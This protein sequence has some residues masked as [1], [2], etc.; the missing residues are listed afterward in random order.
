MKYII[1]FLFAL[2]N[3][4]QRFLTIIITITTKAEQCK[5]ESWFEMK[6]LW[7]NPPENHIKHPILP[8]RPYR[9]TSSSSYNINNKRGKLKSCQ[10]NVVLAANVSRRRAPCLGD[11]G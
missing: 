8:T 11:P 1:S 4:R 6:A 10:V 3:E 2:D 9:P 7:E 5:I